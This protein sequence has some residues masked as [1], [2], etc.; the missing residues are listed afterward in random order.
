M[1]AAS[2]EYQIG[3]ACWAGG[4]DDSEREKRALLL[5]GI[6]AVILGTLHPLTEALLTNDIVEAAVQLDRLPPLS[7]RRLLTTYATADRHRNH[8]HEEIEAD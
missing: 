5:A 7:A 3:Y 8:A 2:D 1:K 6:G 4:I